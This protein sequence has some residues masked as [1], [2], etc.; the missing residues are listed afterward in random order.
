MSR[1]KPMKGIFK[2]IHDRPNLKEALIRFAKIIFLAGVVYLSFRVLKSLNLQ[3]LGQSLDTVNPLF[4]SIS[5]ILLLLRPFTISERWRTVLKL[6]SKA[7]SKAWTYFAATGGEMF[8]HITPTARILGGFLRA[9]W[10]SKRLP[11]NTGKIFGTVVYEQL[12]H[13]FVM[14]LSTIAGLIALF[15]YIG[16]WEAALAIALGGFI[17]ISLVLFWLFKR[18]SSLQRGIENFLNSLAKERARMIRNFLHHTTEAVDVAIRLSDK[19]SLNLRV[20]G[21]GALFMIISLLAQWGVFAALS[22]P[23]GIGR[24]L[25]GFTLGATAG[26]FTGT[27]GGVGTTEASMI[28]LYVLLGVDEASATAAVIFFRGMHYLVW[29]GLGIPSFAYNEFRNNKLRN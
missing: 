25:V 3:D 17:F 23:I 13:E 6:F 15:L 16:I 29:F 12:S 27:P 28:L 21:F 8:N 24:V 9:H 5:G 10:L 4:V 7:P 18:K 14:G 19:R 22:S 1:I 26:F 2:K 20:L 11:H